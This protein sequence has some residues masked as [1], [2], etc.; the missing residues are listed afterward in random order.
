[1]ELSQED[2]G[3]RCAVRV[4]ESVTITL[5]ESPTTG[6]RWHPD[7]DSELLASSDDSFEGAQDPRGAPGIRRLTF[8]ALRA[9][10]TTVR[11]VKKRA[12][13]STGVEAFEIPLDVES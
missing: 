5:P 3:R 10:S 12:W 7:V 11:L 9:G 8:T 4:G 6:Y 1:M 13:E 2:A